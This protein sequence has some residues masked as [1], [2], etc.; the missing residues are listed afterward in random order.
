MTGNRFNLPWKVSEVNPC[1]I[2]DASGFPICS[3]IPVQ[4]AAL[5]DMAEL[6]VKL[7]NATAPAEVRRMDKENLNAVHGAI[8]QER[9][10]QDSKFGTVSEHPHEIPSWIYIMGNALDNANRFWINGKEDLAIKE[11]IQATAVGF[12]CLQQYG[13]PEGAKR[14]M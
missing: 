4:N 6:V 14:E 8:M 11:M 3:M 2:L 1:V 5:T 10:Y 13:I 7:V 12:A 9:F